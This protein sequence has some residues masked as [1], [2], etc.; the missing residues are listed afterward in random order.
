VALPIA[1]N[2]YCFCSRSV[3][4]RGFPVEYLTHGCC[5]FSWL[6]GASLTLGTKRS[7]EFRGFIKQAGLVQIMSRK[8]SF[9]GNAVVEIFLKPL[10]TEAL[11]RFALV[12]RDRMLARAFVY[13]EMYCNTIRRHS[14]MGSVGQKMLEQRRG[15]VLKRRLYRS[16]L[17]QELACVNSF[18]SR[19]WVAYFWRIPKRSH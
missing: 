11:Y 16:K 2:K 15:A 7:D 6:Y 3:R 14:T 17:R 9:W 18:K 4:S 10:K 13:I 1:T 5:Y 19:N 12:N 8:G